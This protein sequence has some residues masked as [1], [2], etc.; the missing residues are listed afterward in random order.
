M[1]DVKWIKI[2][3]NFFDNEIIKTLDDTTVLLYLHLLCSRCQSCGTKNDIQ[4]H[5]IK[6]W[7][8]NK[9]ERYV[10]SNGVTLCRQCHLNAHGGRW[11]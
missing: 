8:D 7:K 3:T 5:H 10:V 11:K 2:P 4:A 6:H 9:N 1:A